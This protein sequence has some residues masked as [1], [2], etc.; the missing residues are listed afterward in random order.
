MSS[1]SNPSTHKIENQVV[2]FED[3]KVA[4]A[5]KSNN[6]LKK[7][8]MLFRL[9]S[10]RSMMVLGK[11]TSNWALKIGLPIKGL[12][13]QTIFHQFC[14]GETIAECAETTKVLDAYNIGTI[15]DYSVEGKDSEA[16]FEAGFDEIFR[17]I[18]TADNNPHIPFC[19]FKVSGL[20]ENDLLEKI[21]AKKRLTKRD[22][23]AYNRLRRRV[24]RLCARAAKANTPIFFDAEESWIQHAIDDLAM[25]MME[26]Y[27]RGRGIVFN[28][29]QMYRHDRM[30]HLQENHQK[31]KAEGFEYCVKLVRGAYMEKERDRAEEK[32]YPSPIQPNKS[33]TDRD[34]NAAVQYCL[35]SLSSVYFCAGTH[36]E[37]SSLML[38]QEMDKRNIS[39]GNDRIFFAQLFGMSDHISFNLSKENYNVAKYVPYGPV[40][41]VMPYLIRRAEENTSVAG[42]T[43]RE[44]NLINK[45]IKRRKIS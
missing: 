26:K 2:S 34:F 29:L 14:G 3:T 8:H 13:K 41:E 44:L 32:G 4:F 18:E 27:N 11:Y 45:E 1:Q 38:A 37:E 9:V 21:S 5:S 23:N 15:L 10:N 42:Q 36:N 40:E 39:R 12:I 16:E 17:T 7:A 25:E 6:D 20:S 19:V 33:A 24:D 43:S 30:A 35:D 28:T 22:E 31:A